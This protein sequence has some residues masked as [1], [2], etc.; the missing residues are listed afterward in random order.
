MI[1]RWDSVRLEVVEGAR[2]GVKLGRR[3]TDAE[4]D[5]NCPDERG[6]C[7]TPAAA[8]TNQAGF[9]DLTKEFS[10]WVGLCFVTFTLPI[11]PQ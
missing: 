7:P 9:L 10:V 2:G 5:S 6:A 8:L 1:L 3:E 4:R 11:R